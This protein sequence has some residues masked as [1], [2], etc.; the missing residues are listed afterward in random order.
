[1][2]NAA[3]LQ[4]GPDLDAVTTLAPARMATACRRVGARFVHVSTDVVFDG[5][6][7]RPYRE[8]DPVSPVHEYG[9]AKAASEAAVLTA[10]PSAVVARTSLLWGDRDDPG[11]QVM[12]TTRSDMSFYEDEYRNPISVVALAAACRELAGRDD[13]T[14]LLH[15]A[16]ADT[17]SRL[18][19]AQRVCGLVGVDAGALKGSDRPDDP[20]RPGNCPL[21][22][23]RARELLDTP[24]TGIREF[25]S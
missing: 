24:L 9:R 8:T 12:L 5:T 13:V 22:S 6:T 11:P 4:H 10:D 14:G 2:I 18:E 17:V 19:F 21:D 16:G 7:D 20:T 3:Y 1:M 25:V 15:V 23:S